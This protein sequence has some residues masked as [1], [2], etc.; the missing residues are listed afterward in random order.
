MPLFSV[1]ERL[2]R[3][4]PA[5]RFDGPAAWWSAHAGTSAGLSPFER[6]VLGG[7]RADRIAWAFAAGYESALAALVPDRDGTRSA[8]LCA[9]ETTGAHPSKITT[10]LEGDALTGE[11]TYVTLGHAAD[12]LLVLAKRGERADGSVDLALVE[13]ARSAAGVRLTSLPETP[14]VPEIPH[15]SVQFES[16]R[17]AR[18][19]PGDGWS[20][21]VRPFRTVEDLHVH[22]SFLGYLVARG[23][24]W[25][26]PRP[27]L[28]RAVST[29]A[30]LAALATEPPSSPG[31]HV[32]LAGAIASTRDVVAALDADGA[33]SLAPEAD[34][35]RF[36]RDRP[37]L[38]V[39]GR[40][41]VERLARAWTK[42]S[43][44]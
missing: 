30:S 35:E 27:R 14:F 29:L 42:L 13:I 11:K 5:E 15:V 4:V 16:A 28:E 24:E 33:W 2:L 18:V 21:Y 34:R 43:T 26:L 31:V 17:V 41:R 39:A 3:G 25:G 19:L 10:R 38:E 12:D 23:I 7:A 9:T 44:P 32:A 1:L 37:L 40:A 6:A 20:A 22:A 8:A 36:T